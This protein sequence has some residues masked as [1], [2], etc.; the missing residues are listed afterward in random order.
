MNQTT[1]RPKTLS[2][3]AYAR[4]PLTDLSTMISEPLAPKFPIS[5]GS[6]I[7][8]GLMR[9]SLHMTKR[10]QA[11]ATSAIKVLTH[12]KDMGGKV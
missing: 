4:L 7:L 3:E 9:R 1:T 11:D 12:F 6:M 2:I 5:A 8:D 10:G